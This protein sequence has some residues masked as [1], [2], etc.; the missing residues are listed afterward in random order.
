MAIMQ[1]STLTRPD[2][3]IPW[4]NPAIDNSVYNF[5]NFLDSDKILSHHVEETGTTITRTTVFADANS[6]TAYFNDIAMQSAVIEWQIQ[7]NI[8]QTI[9]RDFNYTP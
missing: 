8:T 5:H 3:T 1:V 9:T 6:Y 2:H 7:H 4:T